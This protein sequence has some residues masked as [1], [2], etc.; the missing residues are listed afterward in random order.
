MN[1]LDFYTPSDIP[2]NIREYDSQVRQLAVGKPGKKGSL[3]LVFQNDAA[4]KTVIGEQFSEVPLCA[5]RAL[6]CD[7]SCP[8]LAYLYVVS[9]SGG[10]LQGDRYRI[11]IAMEKG[12][13]AHIT[14]QGAT[15]IYSM[16]SNSAM[17]VV[18]V[19]LREG[20][21]LEFI[22]DQII[23]YRNSRFYQ[24]INLNVHD[25][26]TLAYSEVLAP[27]RAAMGESFDYDVCY[28]KTRACN[29][30]GV[31]R[32]MDVANIEPKKRKLS[33][34]GILG[35][36][37]IVGSVYV[38][39]KRRNV[40]RLHE[41]ISML[42]S[43]NKKIA[44]GVSYMKNDTGLLVRILGNETEPVKGAVLDITGSVRSAAIGAPF[45]GIRKN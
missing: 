24:K 20:S 5:Q 6:H 35:D 34:F 29:Q 42:V 7:D 19:T 15:R 40:P 18:N 39:T 27:G 43:E 33:S 17:Q 44:G 1:D 14:T 11:D 25:S 38:L 16:D 2:G 3:R 32:F 4:G 8:D 30:E 21:Y 12:S 22:P 31:L 23:P 36:H 9:A 45:P 41:K 13:K 37:T 26:A 10:I 28:L